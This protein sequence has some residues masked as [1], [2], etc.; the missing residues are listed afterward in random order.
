M[1]HYIL[2]S[3]FILFSSRKGKRKDKDSP[4]ITQDDNKRYLEEDFSTEKVIDPD[5]ERLVRLPLET[6]KNEWLATHSELVLS[7]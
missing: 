3:K 6:D 4:L 7:A 1:V 2:C 5:W